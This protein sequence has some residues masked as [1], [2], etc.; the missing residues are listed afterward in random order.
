MDMDDAVAVVVAHDDDPNV[1]HKDPEMDHELQ[2]AP[3]APDGLDVQECD[4]R[5]DLY[6]GPDDL[7]AH[8]PS[9]GSAP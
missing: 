2:Q 8:A 9:T 5:L 4:V 6:G 1:V 7:D 3:P